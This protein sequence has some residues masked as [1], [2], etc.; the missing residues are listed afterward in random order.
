MGLTCRPCFHHARSIDNTVGRDDTLCVGLDSINVW[1]KDVNIIKSEMCVSGGVLSDDE[2]TSVCSANATLI[3][4]GMPTTFL[5]L[6]ACTNTQ[7]RP[8]RDR[9]TM[10]RRLLL[11]GTRAG[12]ALRHQRLA[13]AAAAA[14]LLPPPRSV[15][16][17]TSSS[18]RGKRRPAP[19]AKPQEQEEELDLEEAA[20]EEMLR[21]D[22]RRRRE[23][24]DSVSDAMLE[25]MWVCETPT[26]SPTS[27]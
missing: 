8:D 19:A 18:S 11:A 22:A 5:T 2:D 13:L 1:R 23:R 24:A 21:K 9:T 27:I 26:A 16:F 12:L 15:P 4:A 3:H 14:P 10:P 20:I 17:S 25:G 7:R 6:F